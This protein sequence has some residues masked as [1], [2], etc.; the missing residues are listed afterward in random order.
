[1][2]GKL[3]KYEWK[4]SVR[5]MTILALAA[6]GLAVF[7]G[8]DL[9]FLEAYND[10][11]LPDDF[12]FFFLPAVIFM[13]FAYIGFAL[14]AAAGQII[15]LIRFYKTRFTDE[16]YLTFTLPVKASQIYLSSAVNMLIWQAITT[17]VI[18]LSIFIVTLIGNGWNSFLEFCGRIPEYLFGYPLYSDLIA[19]PFYSISSVLIT[20]SAIV[21][22]SVL[23]KRH[24]LL[25]S[26]GIMYGAS[27][28]SSSIGFG[29]TMFLVIV[30]AANNIDADAIT[31]MIPLM[32][33]LF[34]AIAGVVGYFI[35]IRLMKTKLNLP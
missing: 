5:V 3:L 33:T 26:F 10:G 11:T 32:I 30:L 2:F 9:R 34:P 23:V 25:A 4:A 13:L 31:N 28:A 6:L 1:M 27:S 22:G 14:Y 35:S 15:L 29:V 24:K 21:I 17:A 12:V 16:G 20:M 7:A 18:I 8:L 19:I